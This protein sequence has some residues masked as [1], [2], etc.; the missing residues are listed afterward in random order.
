MGRRKSSAP[1]RPRPRPRPRPGTK[2]PVQRHR[3][4]RQTKLPRFFPRLPVRKRVRR[5]APR[6]V[7]RRGRA[8]ALWDGSGTSLAAWAAAGFSVQYVHGLGA[9]QQ[10][11][12]A[13]DDAAAGPIVFA[14]AFPPSRD[15]SIAGARWFAQKRA[16]NQRFQEDAATVFANTEALFRRWGCPYFIEGPSVGR[17]GRLWRPADLAYNP[18]DFGGYLNT[19]E[20]HPRHPDVIPRCDA[21]TRPS[22]LWVG[23]GFRCPQRK[24]VEPLWRYTLGKQGR[25]HRLRRISPLLAVRG[26]DGRDARACPPRGFARAVCQRLTGRLS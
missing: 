19:S 17:L 23:G 18:C 22:G 26:D 11:A 7:G 20:A 9:A 12:A 24:P 3:E 1:A 15:L 14:C 6:V 8:I 2:S 13:A 4:Q 16:K 10:A 25:Q 21:Y 5:R